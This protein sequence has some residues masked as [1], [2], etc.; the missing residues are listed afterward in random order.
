MVN[1]IRLTS[2][3]HERF[4]RRLAVL[5][6][7]W[8][9][10]P[11]SSTLAII[12]DVADFGAI[13]DG[14]TLNTAV[15][16]SAIDACA[17]VGGGTVQ[18]PAGSFVTGSIFLRDNVHLNLA[19][20]SQI[21][22]STNVGDY[23][24][25]MCDFPSRADAY[26]S[27][28]LIWGEGLTNVGI[29]GEG[30]IDGRGSAFADNVASPSEMAILEQMYGAEGRYVPIS[31]YVNRPFVIRMVG[32]SD[33]LIE[34]VSL[35]HSAMWMQH[36]QNCD[37]VTVRGIDV[38]NHGVR[39]NDF[40]DIDSSRNVTITD[41]V[42][43]TGD[44]GLTLKSTGN[45]P[46][47]NVTV[48]NC[49]F[50]S[51]CNA[52]KAGTESS[53]GFKNITITNCTVEPS[54]SDDVVLGRREGLAGIAL[55]LVDGG[56]LDGVTVSNINIEQTTSPIFLRLGNRARPPR[57]TDPTPSVG[58]FRNVII[59]D[60]VATNA[61]TTGCSITGIPG[62]RVENVTLC[63]VRITFD[64]GGTPTYDVGSVPELEASYPECTMFGTLPAYGLFARHVD[65]LR[66]QNVDFS[67]NS[68]DTRPATALVDV[69]ARKI[70]VEEDFATDPGWI[71]GP[72]PTFNGNNFGYSTTSCASGVGGEM[73]GEVHNIGKSI[74][75]NPPTFYGTDL[76][77]HLSLDDAFE[78]NWSTE[79]GTDYY[80]IHLVDT[81]TRFG[82]FS[83][84]GT[85]ITNWFPVH[86]GLQFGDDAVYLIYSMREGGYAQHKLL[87]SGISGTTGHSFRFMYDPKA[88]TYGRMYGQY[89]NEPVVTMDLLQTDRAHPPLNGFDT[90]GMFAL[91]I[92]P[93][94]T[95]GNM[96]YFDNVAFTK[97]LPIDL[98]PG[99]ANQDGIVD[100]E[101]ALILGENWGATGTAN[102][103]MG[104]FNHDGNVDARD[105]SLLAAHWGCAASYREATTAVPEPSALAGLLPILAGG[106]FRRRSGN[107]SIRLDALE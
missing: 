70:L 9:V 59:R 28:A 52:I 1:P 65:G 58:T 95:D 83:R 15:I 97:I 54:T 21:L 50:R 71:H 105:A 23:P 48:S 92:N 47:E 93:L 35:R 38:F 84:E 60:I 19:T 49:T 99:D 4:L 81:Y 36:Y 90:F 26:N 107:G 11:S 53:G 13:G 80:G 72:N 68:P 34:D 18:F 63:N 87:K 33:V 73:G 103:S 69:A 5:L 27:R 37:G 56:T 3:R 96:H 57:P 89:N 25:V 74:P 43:D 29:T 46:T 2:S 100:D 22:G 85:D 77:V 7:S 76:P 16:Q 14:T 31:S 62:H 67:T 8:L 66:L 20:G 75:G 104:D 78:L 86:M 98:I 106:L 40:I 42:S 30:T 102:W 6:L 64:G 39:N 32:C 94:G 44:D 17:A 91:P 45:L 10:M 82:Y 61:G 55:E 79:Y 41:C 24:L 51:H 101:D 88:G 12:Y